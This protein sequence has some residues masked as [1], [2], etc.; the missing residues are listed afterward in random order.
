MTG[1]EIF[2]TVALVVLLAGLILLGL[3]SS[4]NSR[5]EQARSATRLTAS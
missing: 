4:A 2:V 3:A 1:M 5:R